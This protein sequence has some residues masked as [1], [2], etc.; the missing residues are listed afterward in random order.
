[1]LWRKLRR[2]LFE[3][4]GSMLSLLMIVVVGVG[5][6]VALGSVWCDL[7]GAR[8][9]YYAAQRLADFSIDLKRMPVSEVMNALASP[10]VRSLTHRVRVPALLDLENVEEPI[11]GTAISLPTEPTPVL[12][13][14]L[15]RS[16]RR[17]SS[18]R[19]REA[20]LNESFARANG[21]RPGDRL[22]V[23]LADQQ[24]DVLIVGT[25]M[26]PEFVY[27]LPPGGAIAPDPARFGVLYMPTEFLQEAADQNGACNEVLGLVHDDSD[28]AV[29]NTLAMLSRRFDSYGVINTTPRRQQPSFRFLADE[30]QGLKVTSELIPGLFLAV[31]A[32]ILNVILGRI[33]TQQRVVIGTLKAIGYGRGTI[34]RHYAGYGLFVG[35]IGGLAGLGLGYWMQG[36]MINIYHEF[37]ALPD[38]RRHFYPNINFTA[39]GLCLVFA[40]GGTMLAVKKAVA[41]EPAEAMHPPPP[42]KGGRVLPERLPFLWKILSFRWKM[43]LRAVFRNPFRSSVS[44]FA[45]A[46]STGLVLAT[47]S[48][49]DAMNYM[50][51][52]EFIHVSHQD[53]TIQLRQPVDR[54][55]VTEINHQ[56]SVMR[57]EPQLILTCDLSNGA[58]SRRT[59]VIAQNHGT[60]LYTPL[61]NE[62][63]RVSIPSQGLVLSRELANILHVHPGDTIRLRPLS[64]ERREVTAPVIS[65]VET[66]LGLN[67]YANL[68]YLNRL[69]GE[70]A[71]VNVLLSQ[72]YPGALWDDFLTK[73][74]TYRPVVGMN[75]RLRGFEQLQGSFGET[76]RTMISIV[77]LFAG[78]IAFG[79]VFNAALVSLSE[80]Q[81]EV[82]TLRVLGYEPIQVTRLFAGESF[83]LNG[84]GMLFGLGIGIGLAHLFASGY[85]SELF[86]FPVRILP[87]QFLI[88]S[89][90]MACY[91]ILAQLIIYRLVIRFPWLEVLNVKE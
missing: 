36:G 68:D 54:E 34:M 51:E 91:I 28:T 35:A 20:I 57:A 59:A 72:L 80:R 58:W 79:S 37:F 88:T 78:L 66:F 18:P 84:V 90:I 39:M 87:S 63:N 55:V 24:H 42:E 64:G 47:L 85:S 11:S 25:A 21:L 15:L 22:K 5:C 31:A 41:L 3:R 29:D 49:N 46:I 65:I 48:L 10:N 7:D 83:L 89:A 26:S 12:N 4:K 2:D 53:I 56:P 71:T 17:F 40:L 16:G 27:L 50:M 32:L 82:G 43:I 13:D 70:Q 8:A 76:N 33:I 38:L 60:T 81:R 86:R 9:R 77:I 52:F 67:A 73:V 44:I 45:S 75:E 69:T 14:V 62:N 61:D 74:K 1:M 19:A 6:F 23:L 30:L